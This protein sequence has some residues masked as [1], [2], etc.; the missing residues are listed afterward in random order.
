MGP[1]GIGQ[2]IRVGLLACTGT[3]G[4]VPHPIRGCPEQHK[5]SFEPRGKRTLLGAPSVSLHALA[6]GAPP[7]PW[8]GVCYLAGG[9]H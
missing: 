9:R 2:G 7:H 4:P 1:V 5:A 8:G 3:P 6:A